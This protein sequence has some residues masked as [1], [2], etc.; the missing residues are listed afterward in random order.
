MGISFNRREIESVPDF[1]TIGI[2][3]KV[4]LLGHATGN[5][6]SGSFSGALNICRELL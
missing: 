4:K 3:N 6:E 5:N 2:V 1:S